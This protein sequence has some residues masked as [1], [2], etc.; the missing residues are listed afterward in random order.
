MAFYQSGQD[1]VNR[2]LINENQQLML[3]GGIPEDVIPTHVSGGI[4]IQKY[5]R[6]LLD[7]VPQALHDDQFSVVSRENVAAEV[8]QNSSQ[9]LDVSEISSH[10]REAFLDDLMKWFQSHVR[11]KVRIHGEERSVYVWQ[12]F[13][14]SPADAAPE[15]NDDTGTE[16]PSESS[17]DRNIPLESFSSESEGESRPDNP[18]PAPVM[19][20]R[21][22]IFLL[23]ELFL[24]ERND[25]S[26][27][28]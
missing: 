19:F 21:Y 25:S 5:L 3:R 9:D 6:G 23:V 20:Q 22:V 14:E 15:V 2:A 16:G 13:A 1:P 27:L 24:V 4:P 28:I 26:P 17:L 8:S 12:S 10:Y 18:A 7:K 11:V